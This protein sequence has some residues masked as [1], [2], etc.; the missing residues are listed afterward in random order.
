MQNQAAPAVIDWQLVLL[1]KGLLDVA[2]FFVSSVSTEQRRAQEAALLQTY[3][4]VLRGNE[5]LD[6]DL[7]QCLL[8][9]RTGLLQTLFRIVTAGAVLDLSSAQSQELTARIIQRCGD[10][11]VDHRATELLAD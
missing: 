8:D 5:V 10:A 2:Y 6:Y 11:L 9:Y 4:S 7:D 3:H 1:G